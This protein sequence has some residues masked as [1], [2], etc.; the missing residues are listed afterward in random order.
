MKS[1]AHDPRDSA[2]QWARAS[3]SALSPR[4]QSQLESWRLHPQNAAHWHEIEAIMAV[5]DELA[6]TP[7]IRDMRE[8]ALDARPVRARPRW[9]L[10]VTAIAACFLA[11]LPMI[12]VLSDSS[13]QTTPVE[14]IMPSVYTTRI[15]EE[16]SV[17]LKDG[18]IVTLDPATEIAVTLSS[19]LRQI[20][21]I[22]G[23]ALFKVAKNRDWPFIVQAGNQ[24]I[25]ATGTAFDV[26]VK[27]NGTMSVLLVEG[28]VNVAPIARSF[29]AGFIQSMKTKKLVPGQKL[30]T[31]VHGD[32]F[33]ENAA[34]EQAS[35]ADR[36]RIVFKDST[37][38]AA[39]GQINRQSAMHIDIADPHIAALRVSGVYNADRPEDFLTAL[40]AFYPLTARSKG[41][42]AVSL[43]WSDR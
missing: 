26:Q 17:R 43:E 23:Q 24:Q 34:A 35:F 1:R 10:V 37:I 40:T 13:P 19:K 20:R 4:E 32:Q 7:A 39:I 16:R 25:R 2:A 38:G 21:L 41:D 22:K 3:L 36:N 30:S 29:V 9:K 18:S 11:M 15:D 6:A 8:A 14:M 28:R 33:V 42:D 31:D 27:P 12:A 5:M